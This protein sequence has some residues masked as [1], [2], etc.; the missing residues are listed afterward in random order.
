VLLN[1]PVFSF[2]EKVSMFSAAHHCVALQ[3]VPCGKFTQ[4][5]G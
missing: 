3:P 5:G 2:S 4:P 1:W